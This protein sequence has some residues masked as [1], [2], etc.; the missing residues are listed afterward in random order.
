MVFRYDDETVHEGNWRD[1]PGYGLQTIVYHDP[2]DG[3]TLRH[4]GDYYRLDDSGA[5]I[6]MD[7]DS[8]MRHIVGELGLV[9]VGSMCS[10]EKYDRIFQAAKADRARLGAG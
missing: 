5:V 10:H 9:K 2:Y 3:P 8:L 7:Y 6:A 1:A 4:Q